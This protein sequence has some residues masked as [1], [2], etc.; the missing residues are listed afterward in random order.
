MTAYVLRTKRRAK[1][2]RTFQKYNTLRTYGS[3]Y[4][5]QYARDARKVL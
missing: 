1:Y 2:A 4:A 5:Y 3:N